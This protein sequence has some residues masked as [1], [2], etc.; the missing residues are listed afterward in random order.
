MAPCETIAAA[1]RT[2]VA[3]PVQRSRFE[4][5]LYPDCWPVRRWCDDARRIQGDAVIDNADVVG[6]AAAG[7]V[8][9]RARRVAG[10]ATPRP[11]RP[12]QRWGMGPRVPAPQGRPPG[13]RPALV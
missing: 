1:N 3:V 9:R 7:A 11:R 13:P 2:P 6:S 10:G 5:R 4:R 8:A 12:P